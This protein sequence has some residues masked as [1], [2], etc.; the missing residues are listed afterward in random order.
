[1][2]KQKLLPTEQ[3]ILKITDADFLHVTKSAI[4][5]GLPV[6]LIDV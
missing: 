4:T 5:N 6:L 3:K 2:V 1:M